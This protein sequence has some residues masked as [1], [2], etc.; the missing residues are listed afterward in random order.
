MTSLEE[1]LQGYG[2]A[3]EMLRS[4]Q[5]GPYQFPIPAEFSNW[6]EEQQAWREGVALM[7]QSF[8]MTD[9]YVE[10]PDVVPFLASLAINGFTGFGEG[11]AKQLVCCA[12][13]GHLIGDMVLTGLGPELVNVIGRPTVA[14]WIEF[15]ASLGKFDVRCD[16]DERKLDNPKPKKTF[17]FEVQGPKAWEM[18]EGLNGGPLESTGF[19]RMG[20]IR[21]GGRSY[22]T[23]R[24]GMGGAP[25]LEFWG[26]V[27][28]Y[29]EVKGLLL[30]AGKAY[31]MRKVGA[32][33]Y[34]SATV[35][36]GWW[37][38]VFPA[39][40]EGEAMRP[41]REWLPAMS[42]DGL[43]SLGGSFVGDS[44][45]EYLFTPWDL[46]Y[47][48]LIRFD[49]DFVGRE[50]LEAMVEQP[51]RR[52]VSLVIEPEDAVA[53]YRSQM[54]EGPKG[55]AMEAPSAHYAAYPFDAVLDPAGK[56]V[57]V[58]CY[59]NFIAPD[60]T[61]V[62]LACVDAEHAAEGTELQL[63]W[64]EPDGGSGRPTVEPHVQMPLKG[65]VTG[66]PFSA[67]ARAGYRKD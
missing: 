61:W 23:L 31:G 49:H 57:G 21:V 27:E 5:M 38:C 65:T 29:D 47:G 56:R 28:Q 10:G 11:K 6:R 35:E 67:S 25:G 18:L 60:R 46:D 19:F 26:P 9:L 4:S 7:D 63:V 52:K 43:A 32:R 17:R 16:R 14:S 34:G 8:H 64:G 54:G 42:Y 59:L 39:I 37:G 50:A 12:P 22:R 62:A 66:W 45:S 48:R 58:S 15:N 55:K 40:Y 51:H 36:S 53:V 13:D 1:R 41:F 20:H 3:L 2:S 24:H 33:A 44:L 30:E